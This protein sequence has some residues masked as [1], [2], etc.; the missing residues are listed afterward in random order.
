MSH[1]FVLN[2]DVIYENYT[3]SLYAETSTSI[4]IDQIQIFLDNLETNLNPREIT[5]FLIGNSQEIL[6]VDI[7]QGQDIILITENNPAI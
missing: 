3:I 1:H 5:D 2:G 4:N 6:K 7:S